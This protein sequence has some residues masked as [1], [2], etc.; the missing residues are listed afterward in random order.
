MQS[1]WNSVSI[2]L[3]QIAGSDMLIFLDVMKPTNLTHLSDLTNEFRETSTDKWDHYDQDHDQGNWSSSVHNR[4][5][6]NPLLIANPIWE[7]VDVL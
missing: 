6:Q 7:K 5:W 2:E 3:I 1:Q 4:K